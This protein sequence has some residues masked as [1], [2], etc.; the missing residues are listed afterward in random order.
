MARARFRA[1]TRLAT[2]ISPATRIRPATRIGAGTIATA[3]VRARAVAHVSA[4]G[5][6]GVHPVAA[7][8]HPVVVRVRAPAAAW[9]GPARHS[10]VQMRLVA[11]VTAIVRS[12]I[13]AGVPAR[14]GVPARPGPAARASTTRE[15]RVQPEVPARATATRQPRIQPG[16]AA[17]AAVTR[18][19]QVAAGARVIACS[20]G[21]A[22]ARRAAR[23]R[24]TVPARVTARARAT[25]RA[26]VATKAQIVTLAQVTTKARVRALAQVRTKARVTILALVSARSRSQARITINARVTFRARVTAAQAVRGTRLHG[27]ALYRSL[28]PRTLVYG[29]PTYGTVPPVRTPAPAARTAGIASRVSPGITAWVLPGI[30]AGAGGVSRIGARAGLTSGNGPTPA[31]VPGGLRTAVAHAPLTTPRPAAVTVSKSLH[32]EAPA[33]APAASSARPV[34]PVT[35]SEPACPVRTSHG[36]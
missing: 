26:S 31:R 8:V 12:R 6:S 24:V 17:R 25:R 7:G 2:R 21:I 10:Q 1:P 3:R 11:V 9:D 13:E 4:P 20:G 29:P 14:S 19:P 36:D 34:P 30:K 23:P 33:L 35:V 5:S 22:S 16:V 32:H 28:S 15:P 18:L 27:T